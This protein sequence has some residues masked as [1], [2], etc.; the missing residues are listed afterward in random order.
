MAVACKSVEKAVTKIICKRDVPTTALIGMPRSYVIACTI[1]KSPPTPI[2]A[3]KIPN[4]FFTK[5]VGITE[6]QSIDV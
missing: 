6:I 3:D 1:M 5:R 4:N 2:I